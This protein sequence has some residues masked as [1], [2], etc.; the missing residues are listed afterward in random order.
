MFYLWEVEEFSAFCNIL[1]KFESI[2]KIYLNLRWFLVLSIILPTA[3]FEPNSMWSYV[4]P[5]LIGLNNNQDLTKMIIITFTG[6]YWNT[7]LV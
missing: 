2:S 7:T 4:S 5:L 1:I 3:I 6:N